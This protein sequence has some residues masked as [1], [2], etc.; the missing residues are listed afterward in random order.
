VPLVPTSP[1]KRRRLA[2]AAA[3]LC[4][5][6]A[7]VSLA[8]VIPGSKQGSGAPSV[9]EGPAQLGSPQP[10]VRLTPADRRAIDMTLDRFIPAGMERRDL[11][12]AWSLAGPEMKSGSTLADWRS[13]TSP[14]PYYS[15]RE[16]TFH[17]W[18]TID[19]GERYV[20]FNLLLHPAPTSKLA[21]YVF[22]GQVVK[23]GGRWLVN[24]LYTIAIMNPVTKTTREV[25]PA[26]FA[27]QPAAAQGPGGKPALGRIGIVPVLSI[28]ALVLLIPVSLGGLALL[29]ARRWKRSVRERARTELPPLPS[30]YGRTHDEPRKK[31]TRP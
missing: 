25:G 19:V 12:V 11:G 21:P 8:L 13:G 14:I 29:R 31:V 17:D 24:R 15:T 18:R 28:L 9:A 16:T 6:A 30:S 26:D 20:V 22:S 4:L 5:V 7:G 10:R 2:W 1:R 27:A 3:L 23:R